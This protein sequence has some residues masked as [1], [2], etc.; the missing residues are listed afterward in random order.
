MP[1][2]TWEAGTGSL[3]WGKHWNFGPE[4]WEAVKA[5][6]AAAIRMVNCRFEYARTC[7]KN[8]NSA[9]GHKREMRIMIS[10]SFSDS[11][12]GSSKAAILETSCDNML[13]VWH[14]I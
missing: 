14:K 11:N 5:L 7:R 2:A 12:L 1:H 10:S 8:R 4:Y 6:A 13:K 9:Y 3:M